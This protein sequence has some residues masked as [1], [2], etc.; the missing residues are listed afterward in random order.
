MSLIIFGGL[1]KWRF[2]TMEETCF[3]TFNPYKTIRLECLLFFYHVTKQW[4]TNEFWKSTIMP[5]VLW[6]CIKFSWWSR[7]HKMIF[8]ILIKPLLCCMNGMNSNYDVVA[9]SLKCIKWMLKLYFMDIFNIHTH[10][11]LWSKGK[12]HG[13]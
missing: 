13:M 1:G 7:V 10:K 12:E 11:I 3:W 8:K 4:T 2:I 6:Q 9:R 5:M